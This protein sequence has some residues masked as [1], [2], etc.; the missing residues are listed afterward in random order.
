MCHIPYKKTYIQLL[1]TENFYNSDIKVR[2]TVTIFK[3]LVIFL[4]AVEQYR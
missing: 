2:M 4:E 3:V 1:K